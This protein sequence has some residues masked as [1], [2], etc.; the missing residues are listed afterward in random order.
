MK[1]WSRV[2]RDRV[3]VLTFT[4]PPKNYLDFGS[5]AELGSL[6]ESL[7]E[8]STD[9]RVVMLTGGVDGYFIAHGDLADLQKAG[10]SSDLPL[11][12]TPKSKQK[13]G[14]E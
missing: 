2:V 1:T 11:R 7:A 4:R 6:L 5:I 3:A 13:S 12:W 9:V 10:T 14:P 8:Q